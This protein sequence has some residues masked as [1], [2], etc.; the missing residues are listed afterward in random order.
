M[1]LIVTLDN[2]AFFLASKLSSNIL[3]QQSSVDR[4]I[5]M[6]EKLA[7]PSLNI[8]KDERGYY[9]EKNTKYIFGQLKGN[10]FVIAKEKMGGNNELGFAELDSIDIVKCQDLRFNIIRF[11]FI[12]EKDRK[13]KLQRY[14]EQSNFDT[15][16]VTKDD[17][18]L[19]QHYL[20]VE[21]VE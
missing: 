8:V 18:T 5:P 7:K 20:N 14:K 13:I 10:G 17:I 11:K 21:V 16:G 2:L 3:Q 19:V 15:E 1:S 9:K 4:R 6:Y 12:Q